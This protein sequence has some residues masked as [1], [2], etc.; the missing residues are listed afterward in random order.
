MALE[1]FM[2]IKDFEEV[3]KLMIQENKTQDL[4]N[5]VRSMEVSP[6]NRGAITMAANHFKKIKNVTYAK[7]CLQKTGS[8]VSVLEMYLEFEMYE[9]A[10]QLYEKISNDQV[11]EPSKVYLPY[12]GKLMREN[13]FEEAL[14]K[15]KKIGHLDLCNQ[16]L[17]QFI[18]IN[19]HTKNS[20]FVAKFLFEKMKLEDKLGEEFPLECLL[21]LVMHQYELTKEAILFDERQIVQQE[22]AVSTLLIF[23][24]N[25]VDST[26]RQLNSFNLNNQIREVLAYVYKNSQFQRTKFLI[27]KWEALNQEDPHLGRWNF[28][29]KSLIKNSS[30]SKDFFYEC[31]QCGNK[32]VKMNQ[33]K[34]INC[35]FKLFFSYLSGKQIHIF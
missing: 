23:L 6:A 11:I 17:G 24:L 19:L 12:A 15:Y 33:N 35:E 14:E 4:M 29:R 22:Q 16:L 2:S 25:L 13:K 7:E 30:T 28:V 32:G 31:F 21:F 18:D 27:E 1:L 10:L 20:F 9:E 5:L 3:I 34:C 26:Q 8:Q